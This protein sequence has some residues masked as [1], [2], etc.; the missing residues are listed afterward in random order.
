[1]SVSNL[2]V[3]QKLVTVLLGLNGMGHAQIGAPESIGPRLGAYVSM[4]SQSNTRKTAGMVQ[5]QTRFFVLF[6]YRVDKA[7]T[8]AETALMA[9]ID[10]FFAALHADLT[11]GGTVRDLQADSVSADE[12]EYQLRAGREYRE[13]PVIVSVTQYGPYEVNP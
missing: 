12:P 10:A 7:E 9:L 1:M 13:Y 4:G 2:A 8:A 3:A 6:V 5:R 11:L